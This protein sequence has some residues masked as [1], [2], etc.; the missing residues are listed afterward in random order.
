MSGPTIHT[1]DTT[2]S[3]DF[4]KMRGYSQKTKMAWN[5][6]KSEIQRFYQGEKIENYGVIKSNKKSD[7]PNCKFRIKKKMVI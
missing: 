3:F 5:N 2:A 4:F 1:T 6:A 7:C